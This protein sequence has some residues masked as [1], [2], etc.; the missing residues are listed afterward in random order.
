MGQPIQAELR[1]QVIQRANG[2]CEYC[3]TARIIVVW[4]V[5]DHIVPVSRG[6]A[7]HLNNLALSCVPCNSH[8]YDFVSGRDPETDAVDVPL[9]NPRT[10]S[11]DDHFQWDTSGTSLLGQTPVGRATVHRLQI[12]DELVVAARRL[13]VAA[14]WHPPVMR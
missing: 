3:Q 4:M 8:K 1:Q 10:Q 14:G 7:T 2:L 13:W 12:N 5:V 6:G 11:W 9:F